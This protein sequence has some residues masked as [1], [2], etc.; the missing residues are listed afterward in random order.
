MTISNEMNFDLY[1]HLCD[2]FL[3]VTKTLMFLGMNE[4]EAKAKAKDLMNTAV[5]SMTS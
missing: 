5:D 1:T 3:E 4:T 2:K